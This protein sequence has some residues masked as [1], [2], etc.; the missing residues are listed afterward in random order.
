MI[1]AFPAPCICWMSNLSINPVGPG[2]SPKWFVVGLGTRLSSDDEIGLALVQALSQETA[3]FEHCVILEDA[4]AAAVASAILE[5]NRPVLIVDAADMGIGPGEYRFFFDTDASIM[6]KS[7]SV[8]THG[9]GLAEG[10]ELARALDFD[11]PAAI[12]GVQPFDLSPR[13][14]MTSEMI[15]RFPSLLAELKKASEREKH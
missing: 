7:S 2:A 5:W 13:Q 4:D 11:K 14:G 6:L 3:F 15:E 12:F 8:S 10:L 9:L 1:H